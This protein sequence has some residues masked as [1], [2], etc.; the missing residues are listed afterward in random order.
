MTATKA[1][2]E[3]CSAPAPATFARN[4]QVPVVRESTPET[5]SLA[6]RAAA[7]RVDPL[8]LRREINR[9]NL[10]AVHLA[11]RGLCVTAADAATYEAA[12]AIVPTGVAA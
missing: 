4:Q 2:P 11:G 3:R 12:H 5:L 6:R 10:A 7:W 9:G 8:T 1:G